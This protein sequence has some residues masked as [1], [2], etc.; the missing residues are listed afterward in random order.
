MSG[1]KLS[2]KSFV[3]SETNPALKSELS[4]ADKSISKN[5]IEKLKD[6]NKFFSSKKEERSISQIWIDTKLE[7]ITIKNG[8]FLFSETEKGLIKLLGQT[9]IGENVDTLQNKEPM[10]KINAAISA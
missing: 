4:S 8:D 5:F 3:D 1:N 6:L 2:H 7:K 9:W 10:E